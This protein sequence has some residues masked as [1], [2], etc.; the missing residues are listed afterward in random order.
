M[1]NKSENINKIIKRIP[2]TTVLSAPSSKAFSSTIGD[3]NY[4]V[5]V[6]LDAFVRIFISCTEVASGT[7][8][9]LEKL[10]NSHYAQILADPLPAPKH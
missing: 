7:Q 2:K 5:T 9:S 10:I 3:L 4:K 6:N 8:E 1:D